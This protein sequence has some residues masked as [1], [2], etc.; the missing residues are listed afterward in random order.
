MK[1]EAIENYWG[2]FTNGYKCPQC[3]AVLLAIEFK[4]ERKCRHCGCTGYIEEVPVTHKVFK[5]SNPA[6]AFY[7][8]REEMEFVKAVEPELWAIVPV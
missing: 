6:I 8:S 1:F 7:G 4:P 2:K 3:G 5:I